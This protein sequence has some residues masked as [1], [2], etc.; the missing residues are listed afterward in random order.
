MRRSVF[1][2]LLPCAALAAAGPQVDFVHMSDT[3]VAEYRKISPAF[4][5]ALG[6]KNGSA[7][8]L[9]R[10]LEHLGSPDFVLITGDLVDGYSYE[11]PGGGP[12]SGHI[13][14]FGR[15]ISRSPV[16]VFPTLG[17]HDLSQYRPG[18]DKPVTDQSIAG[19]ARAA[20]RKAVPQ[21]QRG[22]YYSFRK[23]AGNT[24]YLFLVLDDGEAR[25][26]DAAYAAKQLEW[27]KREIEAHPGD[28]VIL[29][30]HIPLPMA[31][32]ADGLKAII[33]G[34]PNVALVI[35]GHR[36]QDAL[37]Q[38]DVGPRKIAQVLTAALFLSAENCRRF[39]L[40]ED[41]IEVSETGRLGRV[42]LRL[43]AAVPAAVSGR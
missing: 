11:A 36:H 4:A 10:A 22:V 18:G 39:R 40:K 12:V 21:F 5:P 26:R 28:T 8:H 42:V 38:I 32:I 35:A 24:G 27:V 3:H 37:E 41:G 29:A 20:W 15:L 16:P 25:G 23:E 17:N 6:A 43:P 14:L 9:E 31:P 1:L 2:L 7:E 19:A 33:A 13:E 30:M 34:A